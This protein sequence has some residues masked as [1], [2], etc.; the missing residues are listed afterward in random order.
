[1]EKVFL[2][3][4]I[5]SNNLFAQIDTTGMT[6]LSKNT[7]EIEISKGKV[8]KRSKI[9]LDSID[10]KIKKYVNKIETE[11]YFL[12]S[13]TKLLIDYYYRDSYL[14]VASV[15]EY[16]KGNLKKLYN[17]TTFYFEN[18]KLISTVHCHRVMPCVLIPFGKNIYELYG[19]NK[20]L[21]DSFLI[22]FIDKI[23]KN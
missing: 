11:N 12:K 8:I 3:I 20:Y 17:E 23:S 21:D 9:K 5:I 15:R 13:K 16:A 6:K 10:I 7:F 22:S 14:V 2:L 4:L 18:N 1:M 19:Y